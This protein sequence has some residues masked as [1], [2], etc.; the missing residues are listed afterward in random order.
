LTEATNFTEAIASVA[1][2]VATALRIPSILCYVPPSVEL[3][4]PT[5]TT[6]P[7]FK[8]EPTT[9]PRFQTRLTPLVR[10]VIKSHCSILMLQKVLIELCDY[11]VHARMQCNMFGGATAEHFFRI[12][13]VFG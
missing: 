11:A 6:S 13:L 5:C 8:P 2:C 3:L 1:S 12:S 7:V 9:S 4:G 10:Y